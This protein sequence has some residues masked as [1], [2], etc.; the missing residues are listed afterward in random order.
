MNLQYLAVVSVV[1]ALPPI[2]IRALSSAR[3]FTFDVNILMTIAVIGSLGLQKYDEAAAVVVRCPSFATKSL[4]HKYY[5]EHRYSSH[6][7]IGSK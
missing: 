1:L 5:H 7:Q 3:R 4:E 6:S 2:A